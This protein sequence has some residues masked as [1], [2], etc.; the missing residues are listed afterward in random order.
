VHLNTVRPHV[1]A[2]ERAGLVVGEASEPC[3]RGRPPIRYRL[4]EDFS[5]PTTD[6]L[7]LAE[8]L[9]A[10]VARS[11]AGA[12]ELNRL[13]HEWGRLIAGSGGA[14]ALRRELPRALERLGFEARLEGNTLR[15][16]ACPCRLVLPDRPQLICGL[17]VAV[18]EG[19]LEGSG[20]GL[21]VAAR[22]HDPEHRTCN[23]TL[24]PEVAA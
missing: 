18:V 23:A 8:L 9:A 20:S 15:L 1:G 13:G 5:L 17:A 3:G 24:H 2:L 6:F 10:A 4:A 12:E 22:H 16:S 7:G 19:I 21:A 11:G 14:G